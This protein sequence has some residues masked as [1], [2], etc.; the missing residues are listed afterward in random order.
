LRQS[1]NLWIEPPTASRGDLW[2]YLMFRWAAQYFERVLNILLKAAPPTAWQTEA[3][4]TNLLFMTVVVH[5]ETL[6]TLLAPRIRIIL[7]APAYCRDTVE[8]TELLQLV[9]YL[10][11]RELTPFPFEK[12]LFWGAGLDPC[13]QSIPLRVDALLTVAA[14]SPDV[15]QKYL[16]ECLD[17]QLIPALCCI[18]VDL[19][20]DTHYIAILALSYCNLLID[21]SW[22]TWGRPYL[23]EQAMHVLLSASHNKD[24]YL[25]HAVLATH[26]FWRMAQEYPRRNLIETCFYALTSVLQETR[27]VVVFRH[28][29]EENIRNGLTTNGN[30][31]MFIQLVALQE[32]DI[33]DLWSQLFPS[34]RWVARDLVP[35]VDT[36][37]EQA[38]VRA[39]HFET[40]DS[41][42]V[43]LETVVRHVA[44]NGLRNPFTN[45]PLTWEHL[46]TV[47]QNNL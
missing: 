25:L 14:A 17:P 45:L 8:Y 5:H 3:N 28:A 37:T 23:Y 41:T 11:R 44:I 26:L 2:D 22:D 43:A 6:L 38:V 20:L 15:L 9:Q 18:L 39:W 33:Q 27:R 32:P 19:P 42:P 1:D 12:L 35:D 13:V 40:G 47:N 21:I 46:L 4:V 29:I 30:R 36:L 31:P 7:E 16:R 10:L 24:S 34:L